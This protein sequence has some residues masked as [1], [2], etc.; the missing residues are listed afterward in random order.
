MHEVRPSAQVLCLLRGNVELPSG[1]SALSFLFLFHMIYHLVV[2]SYLCVDLHVSFN[3]LFICGSSL[4]L[5]RGE[6]ISRHNY[7]RSEINPNR[8]TNQP[9]IKGCVVRPLS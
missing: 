6:K 7:I 4:E 1:T 9:E 2:L 5:T 3:H 8:S